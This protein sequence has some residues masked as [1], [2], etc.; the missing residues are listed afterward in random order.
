[1]NCRYCNGV[2]TVEQAITTFSVC[3]I[4]QPFI[5]ENVPALVCYL[6]GDKTFSYG[7]IKAMN[8]VKRGEVQSG[9]SRL[10]RVFDFGKLAEP[11]Q[12]LS[13]ETV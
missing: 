8:K 6:C 7:A 10:L 11:F 9:E 13:E 5:V 12:S 4:T 1:M 3:D 2:D